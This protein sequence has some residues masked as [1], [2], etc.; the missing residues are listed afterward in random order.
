MLDNLPPGPYKLRLSLA[1]YKDWSQSG[2]LSAGQTLEV[3][4]EL[5]TAGP[6]PFTVQ[7]VVDMLRGEISPKRVLTLVQQRGVDFALTDEIEKQ[8]RD[9]GGDSDL[10]IAI[11]KTKK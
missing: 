10:L 9:A 7:D 11:A 4:A 6:G 2:T 8:I 1:G 3:Q 5:K